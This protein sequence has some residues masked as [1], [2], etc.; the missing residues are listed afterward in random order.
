MHTKLFSLYTGKASIYK[1]LTN[2]RETLYSSMVNHNEQS[3]QPLPNS[4]NLRFN[5]LV[6][7]RLYK[8]LCLNHSTELINTIAQAMF[9]LELSL[10]KLIKQSVPCND[11][12]E[13]ISIFEKNH[14]LFLET[15]QLLSFIKNILETKITNSFYN[16]EPIVLF[17]YEQEHLKRRLQTE[18]ITS[19]TDTIINALSPETCNYIV[20]NCFIKYTS[21]IGIT[22]Y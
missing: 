4:N 6:E 10:N 21:I 1:L 16:P 17:N 22:R 18:N 15:N 19:I 3:S 13:Q 20:V 14:F 5:K 2:M 9:Y 11:N 12:R 8:E 7:T